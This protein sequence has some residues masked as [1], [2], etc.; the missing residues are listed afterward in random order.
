[1]QYS[2][3]PEDD[4]HFHVPPDGHSC[5]TIEAAGWCANGDMG[6]NPPIG[7]DAFS[8][9]RQTWSRGNLV[10]PSTGLPFDND[11]NYARNLDP[12]DACCACGG[13][14]TRPDRSVMSGTERMA[15]A[16]PSR[17]GALSDHGCEPPADLLG[18]GWAW[19]HLSGNPLFRTCLGST[20]CLNTP[21]CGFQA[22]NCCVMPFGPRPSA[23]ERVDCEPMEQWLA[24]GNSWRPALEADRAAVVALGLGL[25]NFS[26]KWNLEKDPCANQL[27]FAHVACDHSGSIGRVFS[28]AVSTGVAETPVGTIAAE[29]GNL[30]A[31]RNLILFNQHTVSGT[32]PP[33]VGSLAD[34]RNMVLSGTTLSGSIPNEM[35]SCHR[36]QYLVLPTG[37]SGTISSNY[38]DAWSELVQ[39]EVNSHK[40]SGTL[41]TTFSRKL[42]RLSIYSTRLSGTISERIGSAEDIFLVEL[43]GNVIS[44]TLP[45]AIGNNTKMHRLMLSDNM[46]SGTIPV[47]LAHLQNLNAFGLAKNPVDAPTQHSH[48]TTLCPAFSRLDHVDVQ[49][50]RKHLNLFNVRANPQ[51]PIFC[52]MYEQ[53]PCDITFAFEDQDALQVPLGTFDLWIHVLAPDVPG[54]PAFWRRANLQSWTTPDDYQWRYLEHS[55][56]M[57]N[58][59]NGE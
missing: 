39:V 31:L 14:T 34:L 27:S 28:I 55:G 49:M 52:T 54:G 13:G 23:V 47:E 17:P 45:A 57:L 51:P 18:T 40:I 5:E 48:F 46:I 43:Q 21:E 42:R 56:R 2:G 22:G 35:Q 30:T 36:L 9:V 20:L 12:T 26:S 29:I 7:L 53:V 4:V 11:F 59:K 6:A 50:S 41:P 15:V 16:L 32:I 10:N 24:E 58:R 25:G 37:I 3:Y 8:N 38:W 44:G 19:L 1:M 33:T